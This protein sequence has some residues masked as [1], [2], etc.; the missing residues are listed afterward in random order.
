MWSD[1]MKIATYNV[2]NKDIA[3]RQ[4]QLIQEINNIDVDI[5]GLQEVPPIFWTELI[6]QSKYKFHK[7]FL[8]K[9]EDEGLAFLSKHQ[10]KNYCA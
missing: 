2:W 9:D 7:Y 4:E 6:D 3:H 10:I 8:Y 1:D 5:I